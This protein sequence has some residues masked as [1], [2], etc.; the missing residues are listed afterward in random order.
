MDGLSL[1]SK[2]PHQTTA[3]Y[4]SA[5]WILVDPEPYKHDAL[6]YETH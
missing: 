4:N 6:E 3:D 5:A 1:P 2:A